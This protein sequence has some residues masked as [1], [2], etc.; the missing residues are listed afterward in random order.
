MK[1]ISYI[2]LIIIL[3]VCFSTSVLSQDFDWQAS[4]SEVKTDGFQRI[5]LSPTI[6]SK[7]NNDYGD[8]RLFDKD[9]KEIPYILESEKAYSQKDYFVEYKVIEK[10]EQTSWPY[11]TRI[12]IHNPKKSK[13]SN[14]QLIIKNSDVSKS[15][16]LSGSDDNNNWY[17]IKDNYRFQ[18]MFSDTETS[19]I[20]I[21][22]FPIS[23]Y[24][25]Y[26]ILIDDWKDNP[27]NIIKAGFYN[28]SIE[29]GK[30][31]EVDK[32]E[33]SQL[34]LVKEKQSLIK[35][36]FKEIQLIN[37]LTL[38]I[39]GPEFY[40]RDA[41]IQIRDSVKD[42]RNNYKDFF[43][44]VA[45][46]NINS[47]STSTYYFDSFRAKD[48]YIRI[49]NHD[50]QPIKVESAVGEQLNHYLVCKLETSKKYHLLFGNLK[51]SSPIYDIKYFSDKIP[52]KIPLLTT[53]DIVS[54][55]QAK[56]TSSSGIHLDKRII[57]VAIIL[58]IGLLLFMV[59]KMLKEMKS[60]SD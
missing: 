23:N 30:Y 35:L 51:I 37:K 19:V 42:K 18:S 55:N 10:K 36:S 24:E 28:T 7:L 49:N 40:Y 16:K 53:T 6:S 11:Y 29:K 2:K 33:I 22:D 5:Q 48:I 52:G 39:S 27:I 54:L 25:Y 9:G 17:I 3:L 4:I 57:W 1:I 31:T 13:I 41:E 14:F 20:K 50:D 60:K 34:E 26:E 32:P 12:V 15:L 45:S 38:K 21:I 8:I 56:N 58:V 43:N 44:T 59:L 47:N 46:V